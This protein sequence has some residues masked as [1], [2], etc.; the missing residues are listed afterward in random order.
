MARDR[1]YVVRCES[2]A[3]WL[4]VAR[5]AEHALAE[6]DELAAAGDA[7]PATGA[8]PASRAEIHHLRRIGYADLDA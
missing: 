4:V 3:D 2:G 1:R 7:E 8:A 6:W 5:S